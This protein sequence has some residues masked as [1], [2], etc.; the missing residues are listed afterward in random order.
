MEEDENGRISFFNTVTKET[1][2]TAFHCLST[3]FPLTCALPLHCLSLDLHCFSI[4]FSST[5]SPPFHHLSSTFNRLQVTKETSFDH[6]DALTAADLRQVPV[7]PTTEMIKRCLIHQHASPPHHRDDANLSNPPTCHLFGT[8]AARPPHHRDDQTCP[9]H[10][11]AISLVPQL[12]AEQAARKA[13]GQSPRSAAV[14]GKVLA[15]AAYDRR[16]AAKLA[17]NEARLGVCHRLFI[18]EPWFVVCCVVSAVSVVSEV[19]AAS[20]ARPSSSPPYRARWLV[21]I[22]K[23]VWYPPCRGRSLAGRRGRWRARASPAPAA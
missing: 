17:E 20:I 18:L 12:M 16:R 14:D 7:L 22:V 15:A 21:R 11:H 4:A 10:Q 3:T 1:Q 8:A 2:T 6:P 13:R 19:S 5:F 9:I 23:G